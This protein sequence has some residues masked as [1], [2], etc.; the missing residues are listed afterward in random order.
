MQ[1]E[2]TADVRSE[3]EPVLFM[4]WE[5]RLGQLGLTE[6]QTEAMRRAIVGLLARCKQQRV[7]VSIAIA[8]QYLQEKGEG[9]L[10]VEAL[11]W[12]VTRGRYH[13]KPPVPREAG[14]NSFVDPGQ[15]RPPMEQDLGRAPWERELIRALRRRGLSWRTEQT[16]RHWAWSLVRWLQ[17]RTLEQLDAEG[18]RDYLTHLAAERGLSPA[19]QKQALNAL[20][21]LWREALRRPTQDFSDFVRAR[22]RQ[23]LPVVLTRTECQVLLDRLEGTTRL[24]VALLYGAGLRVLEALRLRIQDVD[25]A[26]GCIC[27]RHGKGDKDRVVMLP[28]TLAAQ[29]ERQLDRLRDLYQRDR[30]AGLAGV[31]LPESVAHKCPHAGNEF[32]WQWLFPSREV[33]RDPQTGIVRRHHVLERTIQSAVRRAAAAAGIH[34]R[35]TPHVLRHSFA[36]HLLEAGTDIRSV[37]ELLGHESVETTQIYLHVMRKPGVGVRSPLDALAAG[38]GRQ[39]VGGRNDALDSTCAIAITG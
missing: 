25:L 37:Q 26:R 16:Y 14:G 15:P 19:S 38:R 27:V 17:P 18:L 35:V 29:L 9:T 6:S 1:R 33:S 31:W 5:A 24:I 32:A 12:F 23:R 8:R 2:I 11:R 10:R 30:A 7:P 28:R 20:A 36:T 39:T 22:P 3:T 13:P 34:K 21:F 4:D